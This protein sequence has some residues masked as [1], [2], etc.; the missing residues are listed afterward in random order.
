MWDNEKRRARRWLP[1]HEHNGGCQTTC[2]V[3]RTDECN[4]QNDEDK[5][6]VDRMAD[7]VRVTDKTLEKKE[8]TGSTACSS[9]AWIPDTVS[10]NIP[11]SPRPLLLLAPPP[12]PL[13]PP[14]SL[15]ASQASPPPFEPVLQVLSEVARMGWYPGRSR[16]PQNVINPSLRMYLV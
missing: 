14:L 10:V 9:V 2:C 13:V 4:Q 5:R 12:L 7:S 3:T 15:L 16:R 11:Q 1:D 6:K 8:Y